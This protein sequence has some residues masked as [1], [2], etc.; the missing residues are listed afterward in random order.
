[1]QHLRL[2]PELRAQVFDKLQ[3]LSFPFYDKN[4]SAS[5]INRVTSD[6]QA[7]RSFV[8]GVM[9]QGGILILTLA[10]YAAFMLRARFR[11]FQMLVVRS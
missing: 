4:G 10:V 3:R 5:I 11:G 1:V 6:V 8:D 7:A 9:L 2:V